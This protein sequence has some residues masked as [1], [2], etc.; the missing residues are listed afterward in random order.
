MKLTIIL[1]MRTGTSMMANI[2]RELGYHMGD[3]F[4]GGDERHPTGFWEDLGVLKAVNALVCSMY[5]SRFEVRDKKELYPISHLYSLKKELE[6]FEGMDKA[7]F[8]APGSVF[9][10]DAIELFVDK[11]RYIVCRREVGEL[12]KSLSEESQHTFP[13]GFDFLEYAQFY[14]D[15]LQEETM[16][17]DRIIIDYNDVLDNPQEELGRLIKFLGLEPSL[18]EKVQDIPNPRFKHHEN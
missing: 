7:G 18:L 16:G 9:V 11:P 13:D 17:K 10:L 3:S 6:R 12:A 4:Q 5:G 2:L 14:L 8:K 1:G 15:T